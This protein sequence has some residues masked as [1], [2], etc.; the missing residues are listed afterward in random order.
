MITI[1]QR[2]FL[3]FVKNDTQKYLNVLTITTNFFKTDNSIAKH[4]TIGFYQN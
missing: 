2:S 3:L 4:N 1:S